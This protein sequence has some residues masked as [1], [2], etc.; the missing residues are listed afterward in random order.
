M[1]CDACECAA[2]ASQRDASDKALVEHDSGQAGDEARD[3][4]R[5]SP[6]QQM[7]DEDN[8]CPCCE[9]DRLRREKRLILASETSD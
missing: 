8:G 2:C 9:R 4:E 1:S 7:H 6:C 3:S 5:E